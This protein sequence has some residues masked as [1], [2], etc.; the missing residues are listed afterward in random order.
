MYFPVADINISPFVPPLVAAVVSFFTSMAGVSGAFLLLPFQVSI[1]GFTSPSVSGTNHLF[2]II[3]I[4]GGVFRFIREQRMIWP[5]TWLIIIGTLPGVFLGSLARIH[6]LPD[7]TIFKFF[8]GLVLLYIGTKLLLD[9]LTK[10]SKSGSKA[11]RPFPSVREAAMTLQRVEFQYESKQFSAPTHS[12]LLLSLIV[13]LIGGIYGI[14]GGAIIAPFLV[15]IFKLPV[16][17]VAGACLTGTLAAS[18]SGVAFFQFLA[19]S[20]TGTSVAP[21]YLLGALFGIGGAV[22]IFAGA[23]C[24]RFLPARGIKLILCTIIFFIA[25]SY[26]SGFLL[27]L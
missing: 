25:I 22:G 14:G 18:V 21:D 26:I 19:M 2:N 5:L 23:A 3:A 7:P 15:S 13:G 24:Q 10:K 12:I 9:L 8:A 1:L 4:P 27:S 11:D 17:A 16:H 20:P 6:L